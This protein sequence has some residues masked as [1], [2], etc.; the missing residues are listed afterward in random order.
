MAGLRAGFA[1]ARPDLIR[2][3]QPFR[4]NVI[5]IVTARGVLA[6]IADQKIVPER[7]ASLGRTRSE[8]C[9]WL[10]QKGVNYIEPQAN[11]LMIDV[12]RDTREFGRVVGLQQLEDWE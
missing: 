8:L 5:S 10:R 1:C 6:A 12:R 11:F 2:K 7:R 9:S 3:M 4:N